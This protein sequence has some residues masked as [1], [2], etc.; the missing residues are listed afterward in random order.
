M[1]AGI[2]QRFLAGGRQ[3]VCSRA[4]GETLEI[5]IGTGANLPFYPAS[6]MVTGVDWSP[7]ML[8]EAEGPARAAAAAGREVD[9][10]VA[11]AAALPFGDGSF[12]TVV[13]T[14]ALCCVPNV[15]AVLAEATRVL[16]PG[17]VLLLANHVASSVW[18]LRLAQYAVNVVSIPCQGEHWTRRPLRELAALEV[19]VVESERHHFGIIERIH[20]RRR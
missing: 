19:D 13:S 1:T 2:E 16:R 11:D 10:Q 3:W 15:P 4:V 8:R 12:D 7:A 17:G 20:A 6:V 5:A 9:L 14:Y 18:P